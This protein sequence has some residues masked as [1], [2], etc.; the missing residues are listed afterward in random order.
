MSSHEKSAIKTKY[1]NTSYNKALLGH[2][3]IY[4]SYYSTLLS[5]GSDKNI[6][7]SHGRDSIWVSN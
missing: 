3:I 2:T 7:F 5:T 1:S 6:S 4:Q